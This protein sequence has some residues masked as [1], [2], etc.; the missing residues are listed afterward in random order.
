MKENTKG[1]KVNNPVSREIVLNS[2]RNRL[3]CYF[4]HIGHIGKDPFGAYSVT[5]GLPGKIYKKW[6]SYI[7]GLEGFRETVKREIEEV[8]S[9]YVFNS[10]SYIEIWWSPGGV[11][12]NTDGNACG[13]Y[14]SG[15]SDCGY[16]PHNVDHYEQA[17]VLFIAL[18]IYLSRLYSAME[19]FESESIPVEK[20]SPLE[21]EIHQRVKLNR[22]KGCD[23]TSEECIHWKSFICEHCSRNPKAFFLK[24]K[25]DLAVLG[26]KWEPE[27]GIPGKNLCL[28]CGANISKPIC[29]HC[30]TD[31]SEYF[32]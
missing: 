24:T 10:Q 6:I 30:K 9:Q 25:D 14:I 21:E 8:F 2:V 28:S 15:P 22:Q 7:N 11:T 1:K 17:S 31:N 29:H 23:M 26:D 12:F 3:D 18:S 4:P 16:Y 27:G 5:A 13:I 32:K 20:C 19:G